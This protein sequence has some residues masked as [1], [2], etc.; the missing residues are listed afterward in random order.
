MARPQLTLGTAVVATAVLVVAVKYGWDL[1]KKKPAANDADQARAEF[2][3]ESFDSDAS[4]V[5]DL[6]SE[7]ND[8]YKSDS[9]EDN[10]FA[11]WEGADDEIIAYYILPVL[12]D[13]GNFDEVK[14]LCEQKRHL[15]NV[16]DKSGWAP[17]HRAAACGD[18]SILRLLLDAGA[19]VDL[20]ATSTPAAGGHPVSGLFISIMNAQ[21]SAAQLLLAYGADLNCNPYSSAQGAG[22]LHVF[23]GCGYNP[24]VIR[25][26][27]LKVGVPVNCLDD[28]GNT[29]LTYAI[30]RNCSMV[31]LLCDLGADARLPNNDGVSP[32]HHAILKND[33]ETFRTLVSTLKLD[34]NIPIATGGN[35]RPVVFACARRKLEILEV[36]LALGADIS[37]PSLEATGDCYLHLLRA[38]MARDAAA[39]NDLLWIKE[40]LRRGTVASPAQWV[41]LLSSAAQRDLLAWCSD[42]HKDAQAG[43]IAFMGRPEQ[44]VAP[45]LC[46][47]QSACFEGFRTVE[48]PAPVM[49]KTAKGCVCPLLHSGLEDIRSLV[50]SFLHFPS[51]AARRRLQETLDALTAVSPRAEERWAPGFFG[52]GYYAALVTRRILSAPKPR[53][54]S[55]VSVKKQLITE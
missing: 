28:E 45:V 19:L 32:L 34:V 49:N 40:N 11:I 1:F 8:L 36:L 42:T 47:M 50:L 38:R 7:H 5:D 31:K 27:C 3:N 37:C 12:I 4:S 39:A 15:V 54:L 25:L 26:L 43:R 21:T 29:A 24:N 18:V 13:A 10:L 52:G 48:F 46:I 9:K 14:L 16:Y 2:A 23:S 41:L 35:L 53:P 17:I 51:C 30:N 44:S 55:F 20:P 6:S 33:P 22:L